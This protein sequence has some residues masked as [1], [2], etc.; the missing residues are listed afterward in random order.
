MN[1]NIALLEP[2]M[3]FYNLPHKYR[4]F[5]AGYGSGK[6]QCLID[7]SILDAL[8]SPTA[9]IGLFA[10]TYDLLSLI[11][12]PRLCNRLDEIGIK[13]KYN[14]QRNTI[15]TE[16]NC[17]NF[18][19][20]SLDTPERIVGF[21]LF[22][23][24][25]DELD[26]LPTAHAELAWN[27]IVARCRQNIKGLPNRVSCFTT[28]EGYKFVYNRWVKN[29]TDDYGM[30]QA[31]SRSNPFLPVDYI[32]NLLNNYPPQLCEAYINGQFCNLT[33]GPDPPD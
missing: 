31:S 16:G 12:A 2:Q 22:S 25:V 5:V 24:Y 1:I 32:Q 17:G 27:M 33:S 23:A 7:M 14:K 10:P 6:S 28:P 15:T 9:V 30:V 11:I 21:E 26:T 8:Q 19:F 29:K 13:Y 18:L 3:A 4:A 20:R